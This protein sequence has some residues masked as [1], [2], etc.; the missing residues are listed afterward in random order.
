MTYAFS[1]SED[2]PYARVVELVRRHRHPDGVVV[3]DLGCGF[4]AIAEPIKALGLTYLGIDAD[5]ASIEALAD[6][7]FEALA[8]DIAQ[9]DALIGQLERAIARRPI[10]AICMLDVIEHLVNPDGVLA[11]LSGLAQ[12]SNDPPLIVSIPNVT[13]LD[14]GVKL[15]MGRWDVTPTGLLDA[16]HVRFFSD[17]HLRETM[18]RSGWREID[19]FDFELALSDQHFPP[20]AVPLERSTPI[21]SLLATLR[22]HAGPSPLVNQFVRAYTPCTPVDAQ[23]RQA[24]PLSQP[25]FLSVLVRTQGARLATLQETLL[26]L[27]AQ[28]CD[29][30]EVLVLAHD[31]GA[32]QLAEIEALIGEFHD[33]FSHRVR[34]VQVRGGGRSRPLNEGSRIAAG[35]YIATLDDDDLAFAHWVEALRASSLRAPGQV[36]H[37]G[38]ANQPIAEIPGA[39]DGA[40]GYLV[41]DRPR[42]PYPFVFDQL[43]HLSDN[44]TPN[45]GF[46]VPRSLIS[47]LGEGWDES[48]PVYE[49][50]EYLLRASALCG[51]ESEPTVG[52]L[53]RI[54]TSGDRSTTSHS[55]ADWTDAR[56]GVV[57]RVDAR[58]LLLA[59]GSMSKLR[60]LIARAEGTGGSDWRSQASEPALHAMQLALDDARRELEAVRT[61]TSWRVMAV[62]RGVALRVR[63]AVGRLRHRTAS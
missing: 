30:F 11:R 63:R 16:T 56:M 18:T 9:P 42:C 7:G 35:R 53:V 20:D 54:W 59:P 47:D 48:L 50:W 12:G 1:Y 2:S 31:T 26:S 3:L 43:D 17:A 8:G 25:P 46:A 44:R 38:V 33:R 14:L 15:L 10:A 61:S 62:P 13:H 40:V 24:T 6:R 49:D 55:E 58:P 60:R 29:D 5:P 19:S 36:L 39:S 41:T 37:I 23:K 28:T 52:A 22:G 21:G 45:C 57:A 51:V 4:G 27:A 32:E 34:V